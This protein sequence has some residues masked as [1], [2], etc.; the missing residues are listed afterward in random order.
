MQEK[1]EVVAV[2]MPVPL[3]LRAENITLLRIVGVAVALPS[4]FPW[5]S[6]RN[7]GEAAK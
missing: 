2:A 1:D 5:V 7:C 6:N 3:V 4:V